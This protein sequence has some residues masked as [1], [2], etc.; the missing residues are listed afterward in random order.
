MISE[1]RPGTTPGDPLV[2][3]EISLLYSHYGTG[4]EGYA[5]SRQELFEEFALDE[6]GAVHMLFANKYSRPEHFDI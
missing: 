2:W 5:W 6:P 4:Q 1:T 3:R